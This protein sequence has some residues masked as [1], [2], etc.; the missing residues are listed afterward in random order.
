MKLNIIIRSI[1]NININLL[2][3]SKYYYCFYLDNIYV[4]YIIF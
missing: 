4:L 1:D 2:F 3:D